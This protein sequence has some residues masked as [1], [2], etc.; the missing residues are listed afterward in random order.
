M[1][2]C[3]RGG[4]GGAEEGEIDT[5]KTGERNTL[6]LGKEMRHKGHSERNPRD[7]K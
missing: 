5:V 6:S 3:E 2:H 1:S 4:K 7:K